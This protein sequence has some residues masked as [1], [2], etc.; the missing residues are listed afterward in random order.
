MLDPDPPSSALLDPDLPS[1]GFLDRASERDVLERLVAG[2]RGGQSRVLV[3]RGEAGVGKTALLGHVSAAADGCRIARAAGVESEMEL[4]FAGLHALCAHMLGRLPQLPGPQRDALSTA[5][6]LSAGPPPDR[7]LVALAVLSLLADVAE[8]RPLICIVDDAQW[9]DRVSAQTLAFVARRLLAERVGLLFALRESGD[10]HVLEGLPELVIEGLAADVARLLLDATIPGPLDEGVRS[11]ILAEAGG[12]PL[13]LLELP[14]GLKPVGVAG[15]FGLPSEVPLTSRIEQGFVRQLETL[16]ADTRRLLLLAAAEPVGDVP[17]LW[18][19]AES[20]DIGPAAAAP[21]QAAGLVEIDAR[22]RF[23]HPLVRS[24]AYR[25]ATLPERRLVHRALAEATDARLDPDRRAW[26]RARAAEGPDEAV[27]DELERSAGRA[28]A[29]GGLA[30]AAAF[31]EQ[32]TAL[33]PDPALRG[34]RALAAAEAMLSAGAFDAALVL[35]TTAEGAPLEALPRARIDLLRAQIAFASSHGGEA[36]SLL[37]AAAR[38]LEPLDDALA[39]ETYLEAFYAAVLT[40]P[41]GPGVAEAARAARRLQPTR[42]PR[43]CDLLLDGLTALLTD[44][45]A[46][47]APVRQR[48]VRAF[49]SDDLTAEEGLPWLWLASVEAAAVWDDEGWF[50]L[51][52]LHVDTARAAGA[53]SVLPLTLHSQ[54][55]AHVFAGE[56]DAAASLVA[57]LDAVQQASGTTIAPYAALTLAAWRGREQEVR[58]LIEATLDELIARGEGVGVL[59]TQWARAVLA[60]GLGRYQEAVLAAREAAEHPYDPAPASWALSELVE[61]A[62][63]SGQPKLAADAFARLEPITRAGDTDWAL[64]IQAR[65]HALLSEGEAA[66]R[67]YREAIKR[68]GRTRLR[69]ELAR[70]RLLYGEWLRRENRRI[71]ARNEL[72]AV[73]EMFSG[74]GAEGFAERARHELAATG[75]T[76]RRRTDEVRGVLTPQE[77]HIA[78]LAKDGLSNDEIGAQLFISPRT[79]QYHLRK[80]FLKLDITSR[81]QLRRVPPSRLA[82]AS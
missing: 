62:T 10:E 7:F 11:R 16:S 37:L 34:M 32:A 45:Y 33:T 69:G 75:E 15:G 47:A 39:R 67:L 42:R 36:L 3:V 43:L 78:R 6:G 28:Q 51:T 9:L 13:A 25:A 31:L 22:V 74:V 24:A 5:F 66:E 30:A 17:L 50:V 80:V 8:E 77:A 72:R 44:G 21:A 41:A 61:G 70:A 49:R 59:L 2:V 82:V 23:R 68:L 12:N 53:L 26:H 73:H 55:V 63:R 14:R 19:A 27:A 20:L 76:A 54:A 1:S 18:R 46:V 52:A 48:A 57:E 64:G 38:R 56:L 71:D 60:N 40:D 4:A 29:R 79:V 81:R 65:A 58:D 35:L